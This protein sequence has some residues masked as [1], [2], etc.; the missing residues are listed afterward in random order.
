[1]PLVH[2]I[3]RELR[4]HYVR[5]PRAPLPSRGLPPFLLS[6]V[7]YVL[8]VEWMFLTS[9]VAIVHWG[10]FNFEQFLLL[11][12]SFGLD[13]CVNASKSQLCV[14]LACVFLAEL[15]VAKVTSWERYRV[16]VCVSHP[17]LCAGFTYAR[18]VNRVGVVNLTSLA[19][20]T[21]CVC[22]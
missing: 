12:W 6:V 13:F 10:F 5:E 18:V 22:L 19:F 20:F 2:L 3:G 7:D 1:M 4:L 9:W 14:L 16:F 8:A 11:A 15:W 21:F 17:R